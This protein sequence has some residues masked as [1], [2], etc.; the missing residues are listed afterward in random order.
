MIIPSIDLMDGKAVQLRR[1]KEKMLEFENV[2]KLVKEFRKFGEIAV[3]DL[4]AALGKGDNLGL[5]K[6]I[7]KISECRVGGGIRTI[8]RA[9]ELIKAGAKK[10][11]I[12]TKAS[13]DFLKQLPKDKIIV[14]IDSRNGEVVNNGWRRKTGK[15]PKQI[16]RELENY[17]SGFL[18]TIVDREGTLQGVDLKAMRDL[19]RTTKNKITAAGGITSMEEIK[20]LE[21]FDIDSQVGMGLYTGKINLCDSFISLLNFEKNGGL[22]PTIVQDIKGRILM[23]A[24]SSKTSLRKT[25]ESEKAWYYSRSRN[26]LWMKGEESGNIQELVNVKY[27]CDRDTLLFTVKPKGFACHKGRYSCFGDKDFD[28]EELYETILDRIKNPRENSY[29]SK[30][31]LRKIKRKINEEAY[32]IIEAESKESITSEIADLVYFVL[33]L[34][35][36]RGIEIKDVLNELE[37]RRK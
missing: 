8:E 17:C 18:Y 21:K 5:I 32:E 15:N 4:D 37:G 14:A 10:I 33:V 29:T 3:I 13:K 16:V 35:A 6:K 36:K 30:L 1:G 23:L 25:F 26:K 28:L 12:G 24:Y 19:S 31:T 2:M 20:E 9:R 27:D 34:M 11:I 7:C 22:T